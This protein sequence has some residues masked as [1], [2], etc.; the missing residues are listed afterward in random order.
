[1]GGGCGLRSP[2]FLEE[3]L[4][5]GTGTSKIWGRREEGGGRRGENLGGSDGQE[6][7]MQ[8]QERE[9]AVQKQNQEK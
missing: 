1:M 2:G 9:T 3:L 7:R 6:C 5:Y 4:E 8:M